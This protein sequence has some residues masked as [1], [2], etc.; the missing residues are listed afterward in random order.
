MKENFERALTYILRE[1][2]GLADDARDPGGLTNFGITLPT[3]AKYRGQDVKRADLLALT[4][5]EA[6]AIY[7]SLYWNRVKGDNLPA[8]LDLFLFDFAVNSGPSRAV[9]TLQSLIGV[10]PDGVMGPISF[11]AL[12]QHNVEELIHK[13][14]SARLQFLKSLSIWRYFGKGWMKRNERIRKAALSWVKPVDLI[15]TSE[16]T[17]PMSD[18]FEA[19]KPA[20]QSRT[21]WANIIGLASLSLSFFGYGSLD[22]GGLTDAVLQTVAAGSFIASTLFRVTAKKRI[23]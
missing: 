1:E 10:V 2:G 15:K 16:R 9:K 11:S 5:E 13:L 7:R 18:T 12:A 4:Q 20:L 14:A 6:G 22:V 21:V 17:L 19:T 3:L 8:G 23:V